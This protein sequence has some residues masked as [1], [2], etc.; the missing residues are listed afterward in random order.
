[1][2]RLGVVLYALMLW[3]FAVVG[4]IGVAF[5]LNLSS[6]DAALLVAAVA[7]IAIF[8]AFIP[9]LRLGNRKS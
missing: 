7:F 3:M 8:G 5:V 2:P 4:A 1:M 6:S 9:A